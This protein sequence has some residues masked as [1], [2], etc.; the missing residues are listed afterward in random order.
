MLIC[1]IAKKNGKKILFFRGKYN[2]NKKSNASSRN[3]EKYKV[4]ENTLLVL[5]GREVDNGEVR[6]KLWNINYIKMLF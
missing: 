1:S 6:K 3:I 4:F 5:W 2:Q